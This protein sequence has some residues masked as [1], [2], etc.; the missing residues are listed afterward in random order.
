MAVVADESIPEEYME[1]EDSEVEERI[2]EAKRKLGRSLLI[3]GHHYQRDSVIKFA[4]Q[5]G[6]SLKLSRFAASSEEA[7]YIVFCGVHFMAESA[8]ILSHPY[9]KVILP[10]MMAGC[11]LAEMVTLDE[12]EGCWEDLRSLG[13][14]EVVPISYIN[15][16]ADVKAFCGKEGGLVCTSSN[17]ADVM[18]WAMRGGDKVLFLPDEHLGR[19][20]GYSIGIGLEEMV[21]W[22]P[23]EPLGGN[24]PEDIKKAK[25]ILW[26]GFCSVHMRFSKED[27]IK[28]RERFPGIRVIV[29]PE[30]IHE[31]VLM[32]D[33]YGSTERI[34][35]RIFESPPGSCWAI[36]TEINLVKRLADENKDKLILS[37]SERA[38]L[39]PFMY[40]IDPP[41]LL[42]VLDNILEGRAVNVVEVP[43]DVARW[44]RVGLERMLEVKG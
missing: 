33:E 13:I 17:A 27:V 19:N 28:V 18:R 32:A 44:A 30:C 42:W 12:L 43:E 21:V 37:L 36:G 29:H 26:K 9:Q 25:L 20:T 31:V 22:D 3:L 10:N 2:W 40:R 1:M 16:S 4:D 7:E 38:A 14:G 6:D 24:E 41:H 5:R 23:R 35:R 15:S 34:V 11:T 39:C 8:D